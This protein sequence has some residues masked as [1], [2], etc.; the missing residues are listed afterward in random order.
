MRIEG[1][2]Q[3]VILE[4]EERMGQ[5]QKVVDKL[6]TGDHTK[7][8]IEDLGKAEKSI[9]YSEESSRTIHELVNI[10]LHELGQIS[11]TA[12]AN[13]AGSTY[14][15]DWFSALAA[16]VFDLMRNKYKKSKP[17]LRPS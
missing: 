6:R 12:N 13:L 7:S 4:D 17:D 5:I 1:I 15:R 11:R 9:K 10:E 3:D 2:A 8:I 14:P 16:F